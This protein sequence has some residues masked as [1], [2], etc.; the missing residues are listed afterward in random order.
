MDHLSQNLTGVSDPR[1]K[2]VPRLEWWPLVCLC[3]FYLFLSIF[4]LIWLFVGLYG[5]GV[6][7]AVCMIVVCLE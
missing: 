4:F 5:S 7:D 3:S 6:C 2:A 1:V